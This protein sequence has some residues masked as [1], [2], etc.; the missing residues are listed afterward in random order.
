M[1]TPHCPYCQAASPACL[2]LQRFDL[3]GLVY[4]K[5]C[6]NILGVVT[7]PSISPPKTKIETSAAS[8]PPIERP[9][10]KAEALRQAQDE[11]KAE[12]LRQAQEAEPIAKP[13]SVLEVIGNADLSGKTPY[14]PVLIANQIRAAGLNRGSRYLQVAIDD[15]PPFCPQHKTEMARVTIPEGYKNAGRDVWLCA[16]FNTCRQWELAK[17]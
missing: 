14:D 11:T 13:Q 12:A 9:Q 16:Q 5:Q 7:L 1:A 17:E 10:K 3:F 4:C 15:G 8:D 6:G 2:A